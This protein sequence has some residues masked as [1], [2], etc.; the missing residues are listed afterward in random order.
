MNIITYRE[1]EKQ[2]DIFLLILRSF[3]QAMAREWFHKY[4]K[5]ETRI[6]DGPVGMCG[7]EK[8]E[9]V[10]FVGIMDIPTLTRYGKVENVGGIYGVAVKPTYA[11]LGIGKKL[12][13]AAEDYLRKQ[14]TRLS[15][16]TTSRSIVAYNWYRKAGY[17]DVKQID[18]LPH[19]YKYLD[20]TRK[21]AKK[22]KVE[23]QHR[24]D[25]KHVQALFDQYCHKHCGFVLRTVKDLKAREMDGNFSKKLSIAMEDGYAL[26]LNR[27]DS[28]M[29]VEILAR[30]Q[31]AYRELIKLAEAKAKYAMVALQPFAPGA[32]RAFQKANYGADTGSYAVL[33]CKS[34]GDTSFND[35]YDDGFILSE[36]DW[37]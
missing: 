27:Y 34:L 5:Y 22:G 8:G 28:L 23:K 15:F 9:F 35:L 33:M 2:D 26:L 7:I 25:I 17:E 31:K 11:R 4:M 12:L 10:G 16:L 30:N 36:L 29:Y 1:L 19:L 14:G 20:P 13:K 37:F 21:T 32:R 6:G 3:G 18:R 24:I